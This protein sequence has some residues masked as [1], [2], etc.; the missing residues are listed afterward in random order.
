[1]DK[2]LR[3]VHQRQRNREPLASSSNLDHS[4]NQVQCLGGNIDL[5]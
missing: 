3:H 5:V 1:L 2:D 4:V